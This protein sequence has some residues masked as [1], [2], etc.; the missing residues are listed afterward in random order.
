L[1]RR[2]FVPETFC[3]R[4]RSVTETFCYG[5]V[6]YGD[7]LS[8]RRFVRKRFVC[9]PY[10]RYLLTNIFFYSTVLNVVTNMPNI[11]FLTNI[12]LSLFLLQYFFKTMPKEVYTLCVNHMGRPRNSI[13]LRFRFHVT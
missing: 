12:Q 6:L 4:R 5:D 8:R 7:V 13:T 2:R 10:R 3:Y 9:A 1:L 11:K